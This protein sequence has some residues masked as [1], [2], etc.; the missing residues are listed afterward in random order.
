MNEDCIAFV[1]AGAPGTGYKRAAASVINALPVFFEPGT[2]FFQPFDLPR[3]D[4]PVR[5][6]ADV[7]QKIAVTADDLHKR[8]DTLLERFELIVRFPRP[9]LA[10]CHAGLPGPLCLECADS[11]LRRVVIPGVLVNLLRCA[12][13]ALPALADAVVDD[14]TGLDTLQ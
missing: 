11:L 5:H 6:G 12:F 3:L 4:L 9:L 8:I 2:H 14:Q 13:H 10:D 1:R 7:K